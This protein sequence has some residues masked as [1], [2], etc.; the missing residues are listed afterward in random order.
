MFI[1]TKMIYLFGHFG[2]T[3]ALS[4]TAVVR[5]LLMQTIRNL[6]MR[7]SGLL[8]LPVHIVLVHLRLL[9]GTLSKE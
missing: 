7:Q 1:I 6:C 4:M 3:V 5:K 8:F 2:F 9:R